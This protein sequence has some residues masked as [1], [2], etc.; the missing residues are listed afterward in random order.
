MIFFINFNL[1]R[2]PPASS[3]YIK[4]EW[5]DC[6]F[7]A[8]KSGRFNLSNL[9]DGTCLVVMG[10]SENSV[11][12]S[13]TRNCLSYAA[14]A[15]TGKSRLPFKPFFRRGKS[16]SASTFGCKIILAKKNGKSFTQL[17]GLCHGSPVHFV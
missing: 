10:Q 11:I 3:F 13:E 9:A 2:C 17:K 14:P 15:D 1:P 4:E 8:N 6:T 16:N 5:G 12:T 7:W